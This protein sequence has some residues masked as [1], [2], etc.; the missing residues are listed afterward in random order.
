[1]SQPC[2]EKI[3]DQQYTLSGELTMHN[4]SDISRDAASLV[5]GMNGEVTI[6]LSNITRAD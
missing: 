4:V 1:M 2:L 3:N 5:A 6:N